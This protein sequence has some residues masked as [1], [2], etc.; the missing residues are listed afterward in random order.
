[1]RVRLRRLGLHLR[2]RQFQHVER[3]RAFVNL[4]LT[5]LGLAFGGAAF[6][7]QTLHELIETRERGRC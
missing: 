3:E 5:R 1:V 7:A 2:N 4:V 6:G